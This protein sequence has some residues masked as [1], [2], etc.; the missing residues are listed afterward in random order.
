MNEILTSVKRHNSIT[1]A[2]KIMYNNINL[3]L[4]DINAYMQNLVNF[5][6]NYSE[7]IK[8]N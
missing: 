2:R 4:V 8:R 3:Y 5:L 6:S 7:D 1:N